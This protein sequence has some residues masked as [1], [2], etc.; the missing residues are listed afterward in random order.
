MIRRFFQESAIYAASSVLTRGIALL[1]VPFYTRVL[2]PADY[3][4]IEILVV[5]G[6]L[7]N[8]VAAME[9]SQ[10][11]ARYFAA[12]SDERE[13]AGYASTALWFTIAAYTAFFL[14]AAAGSAHIAAWILESAQ[15]QPVFLAA[16]ASLWANGIFLLLQNQLR[17]QFQVVRYAIVS[18]VMTLT[19]TAV[20]VLLVL[21]LDSGVI[22]VFWG[23]FAGM[24]A[25]LRAESLRSGSVGRISR[26]GRKAPSSSRCCHSRCLSRYQVSR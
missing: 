13:R 16:A 22:G 7:V 10:G 2:T 4:A 3:G 14:L 20:S 21:G 15:R 9:I 23:T 1:L 25:A 18:I 8:I 19:S 17:W 12:D 24:P 11:M 6:G 5:V 26:D